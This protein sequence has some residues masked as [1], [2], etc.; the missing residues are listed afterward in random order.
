MNRAIPYLF[1]ALFIL[2][3]ESS[4]ESDIPKTYGEITINTNLDSFTGKAFSF[5][6]GKKIVY[7]NSKN[8]VPDIMILVHIVENGD[9][10]GVYLSSGLFPKQSFQFIEQFNSTDSALIFFNNLTEIQDSNFQDLALPIQENQ[11]WGVKTV[12]DKFGKILILNTI[13]FIDSSNIK[14]INYYGEAT[15]KWVY[16]PNGSA[17]F[18]NL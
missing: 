1:L 9:L 17:M 2:S 5:S 13:A 16:Q 6:H 10:R 11:I 18:N 14:A 3:C 15:F 4:V 8:I 12:D 7:P